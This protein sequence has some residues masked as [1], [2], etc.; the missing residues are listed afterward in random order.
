MWNNR[1]YKT[2]VKKNIPGYKYN[3]QNLIMGGYVLNEC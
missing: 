1:A 2:N 3:F